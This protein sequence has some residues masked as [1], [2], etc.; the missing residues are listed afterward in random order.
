MMMNFYIKLGLITWIIFNSLS[1]DALAQDPNFSQFYNNPVYYNPAMAAIGK[2]YTFRANARN[3]WSPI[4][5]RFNTFTG[6]FE[7]EV[8]NKLGVGILGYSDVAGEG[9]LRTTGGYMT[10]SYRAVETKNFMI[11][12]GA[13][14]GLI[15][16]SVDWSR[17]TFSDQYDELQGNVNQTA[18]VAPNYNSVLYPDFSTGM[19]L[20]FNTEKSKSNSAFKRMIGTMGFAFHHLNQPKDAF[21]LENNY[22]PLKLV[23]HSTFSLLIGNYI[24]SPGFIFEK[25][26]QFQTFT[27]GLSMVNKPMSFGVWFRNRTYAMSAKSYDSFIFTLGTNVPLSRERNLRITYGIDFTISRLRTSSFGS[28]ELSLVYDLDNRYLLKNHHSKKRKQRAYQCPDDFMG[29]D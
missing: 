4:P 14:A 25:Q 12:F 28:H 8:L 2:G 21:I 5:G 23:A 7:G 3:L 1:P 27:V 16:K 13:S 10:Y 17:F 24:Y 20:R 18:F 22:L 11:Q 9:M 15:N 6:A 26:N 29:W 19:A